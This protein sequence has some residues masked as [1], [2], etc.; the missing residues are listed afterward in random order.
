MNNKYFKKY[1]K[2][3]KKYLDFKNKLEHQEQQ[4]GG[5]RYLKH[6]D[7]E[8]DPLLITTT[9]TPKVLNK[10]L[11]QPE[12][13][14][15]IKKCSKDKNLKKYCSDKNILNLLTQFFNSEQTG[16]KISKD[17]DVISKNSS[18]PESFVKE[19]L[20]YHNEWKSEHFLKLEN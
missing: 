3:K 10:F 13:N 1:L 20:K 5:K 7:F 4:G 18:V 12:I 11:L 14:Y 6:D 2:Y 16:I 15:I 17:I 8:K 19:T 9:G